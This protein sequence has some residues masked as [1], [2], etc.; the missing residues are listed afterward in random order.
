MQVLRYALL[1]QKRLVGTQEVTVHAY[2]A[3]GGVARYVGTQ[4]CTT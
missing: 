1:T 2:D 3:N 4:V